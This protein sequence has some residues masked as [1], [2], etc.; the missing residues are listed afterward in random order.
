MGLRNARSLVRKRASAP[1]H[2]QVS[3]PMGV[4][5][6]WSPIKLLH[7]LQK[8]FGR[9]PN[10][11]RSARSLF[12]ATRGVQ[13]GALPVVCATSDVLQTSN[14]RLFDRTAVYHQFSIFRRGCFLLYCMSRRL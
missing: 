8:V 5:A 10:A 2:A 1:I 4:S 14:M 6:T 13:P 9:R 3:A 11:R 7:A 12:G